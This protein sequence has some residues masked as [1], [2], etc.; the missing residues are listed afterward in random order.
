MGMAGQMCS[1]PPTAAHHALLVH[2]LI[3]ILLFHTCCMLARMPHAYA[4]SARPHE[5]ALELSMPIMCV[6]VSLQAL[7]Y[8]QQALASARGREEGERG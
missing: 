5:R 7:L 8:V 4:H 2:M 6:F 1:V 3:R